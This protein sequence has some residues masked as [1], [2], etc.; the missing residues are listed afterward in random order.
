MNYRLD[1]MK[2]RLLDMFFIFIL[3]CKHTLFPESC[4]LCFIG[5][6]FEIR[7]ATSIYLAQPTA[8]PSIPTGRFWI[9]GFFLP[10]TYKKIIMR[11]AAPGDDLTSKGS[12]LNTILLEFC[13]FLS[14]LYGLP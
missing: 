14:F 10:K 1:Y 2:V 13:V 11:L 7:F 9:E 6:K 3:Y 5:S 12:V 8:D 4:L